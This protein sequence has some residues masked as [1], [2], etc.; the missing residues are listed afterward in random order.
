MDLKEILHENFDYVLFE[1]LSNTCKLL[2]S[3]FQT[4]SKMFE[5]M[6]EAEID[7]IMAEFD[8]LKFKMEAAKRGLGLVNKLTPGETKVKNARRVMGNMNSIRAQLARVTNKVQAILDA[9]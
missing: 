6:S 3:E 7:Q 8:D 2:E 5:E 1:D 4:T 9:E